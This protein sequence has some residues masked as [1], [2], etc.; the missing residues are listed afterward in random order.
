[1]FKM[2]DEGIKKTDSRAKLDL[3]GLAKGWA[4]D[5]MSKQLKEGG[6]ES[7]LVDWGG[8][9]KAIGKHPVGRSWTAAVSRPPGI[10]ELGSLP[11][12]DD[13][14]AHMELRDGMSV[15]TSGD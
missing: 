5:E 9:I 8:D 13:F 15:A 10:D 3:C 14:L 6:F 4:I 7:A 2:D 1:M 12:T 11:K